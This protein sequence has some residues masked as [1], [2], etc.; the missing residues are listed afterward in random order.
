LG[1][2]TPKIVLFFSGLIHF[3][4]DR[5]KNKNRCPKS[6]KVM[7]LRVAKKTSMSARVSV[8]QVSQIAGISFLQS[9]PKEDQ[10]MTQ[11][12]LMVKAPVMTDDRGNDGLLMRRRSHELVKGYQAIAD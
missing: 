1:K 11:R 8:F 3:D 2:M 12:P 7:I 4:V 10:N 9:E 5:C 6:G